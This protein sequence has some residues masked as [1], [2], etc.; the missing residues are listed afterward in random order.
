LAAS[1]KD[2]KTEMKQ[3]FHEM[4]TDVDKRFYEIKTDMD[5]RFEQ[6]DKR[7]GRQWFSWIGKLDA[8]V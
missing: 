1:H 6:V 4:K 5:K 2:L 3:R 8:T 7:F